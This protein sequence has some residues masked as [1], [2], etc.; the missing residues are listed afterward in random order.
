MEIKTEPKLSKGFQ[1]ITLFPL[2]IGMI[3]CTVI[4][5]GILFGSYT[6]WV[7]DT[8]DYIE[9][10]Q[11]KVLQDLSEISSYMFR[12]NIEAVIYN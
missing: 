2:L 5:I 6:K 11:K 3:S 12:S 1:V 10:T 4:I 7:A 8:T 9:T